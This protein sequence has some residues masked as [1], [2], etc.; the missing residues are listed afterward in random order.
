M[1]RLTG[2]TALVTGGSRG[3]GAGIA[4]RLASEG[5]DVVITYAGNKAAADA[6]VAAIAA[7]GRKGHA[8]QADAGNPDAVKAAV[9]EAAAALGGGIDILVHNAGV[10]GLSPLGQT[11]DATY[12]HQF[13][14][15]VDGVYHGTTAAFPHLRDGGRVI[16]I[17]SVNGDTSPFPG[18]AVYGATKAAVAGLARGW[19]QDLA[20]RNI[21]VNV[22]QPGPIDTDMNPAD[23]PFS[24][25]MIQLTPLKR[26]GT[27]DEVAS[28]AAFLA[29]DEAS[30]ITGTTINVDGGFSI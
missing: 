30:Y 9:A 26:F 3:I 16:I 5:A 22:I 14:T 13:A 15:N 1:T 19:A 7:S 6:T 20:S 8:V 2:K 17:G 25:V 4:R 10:F 21:L 18:A 29:S 27:V 24:S 23:G 11:E 12:R 28:V